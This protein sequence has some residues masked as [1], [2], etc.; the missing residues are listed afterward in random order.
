[1]RNSEAVIWGGSLAIAI[2]GLVVCGAHGVSFYDWRPFVLISG[3]IGAVAAFYALSGR[4]A[5]IAGM[6]TGV[7]Q[8]MLFS[9]FGAILTY[10][11]A[12]A[13]GPRLF[14][15]ELT[16]ADA[17]LGFHWAAWTTAVNQHLWLKFLFALVYTSLLPQILLSVIIFSYRGWEDRN[18]ELLVGAFLAMVLTCIV[19]YLVPTLG[20]GT[21][22][23]VFR[24]AY[25][26]E[27][28][29]LRSHIGASVDLMHLKGVV[30]FPSFHAVLGI[31][32][33]YAH[34]RSVLFVPVAVLNGLMLVAIPSEGGHYLTDLLAGCVVAGL[35]IA[36][37]RMVT[38]HEMDHRNLA[39]P[40]AA[41]LAASSPDS[42]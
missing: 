3:A 19:Y 5:Q 11:I 4:S 16:A 32:F 24:E 35:A 27:L 20:P 1:M 10:A 38:R 18:R 8:W 26:D 34:R 22:A 17:A 25:I 6:A 29:L 23:P 7:L 31:L 9:L 36:A 37:A 12:S 39:V 21:A 33:I 2:F 13:Q 15:A 41:G 42:P 40:V 14:D 28:V 30:A